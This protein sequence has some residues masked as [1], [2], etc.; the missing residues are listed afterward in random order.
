M[1]PPH[2]F[3]IVGGGAMGLAAAWQLTRSGHR[4][5]VLD[6][7]GPGNLAGASHGATRNYN[8]A[9]AEPHYLALL[10]EAL[11]RWRDLEAQSGAEL[12]SFWG[13]VT[14]GDPAEVHAAYDALNARM[15][16]VTML[17]ASQAR[18]R[19][20][21]MR[22]DGEV[23]HS[24]EAGVVRAPRALS[25]LEGCAESGGAEIRPGVRATGIELRPAGVRISVSEEGGRPLAPIDAEH[26]IVTAGAWTSGLLAG[27]PGFDDLP[28]ITVTEEQPEH[29]PVWDAATVWPSFNH[30]RAAGEADPLVGNVYGM[31]TPGE[32][33]KVGL[34][35]VGPTVD[36][37]DRSFEAVPELRRAL[38]EYVAEWFPGVDAT[39][40]LP[41]SCTY[42]NTD[43]G[44][45]VLDR[46]G[47]VT[48]GAGFS[49][50]GFKFVP[51]IGRV[52][53]DLATGTAIAP[54]A[55]Q[56]AR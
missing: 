30:F 54:P 25:A 40:G 14:H 53:A 12:L 6:R 17:S 32:G 35:R 36:P 46:R 9:Y 15:R 26:V 41:V 47:P 8:D 44:R 5:L 27:V 3:V 34:H 42:A 52:L 20:S 18:A 56:I 21:G 48:V 38:R 19:Y 45:F 50:H 24:A 51:A 22:F 49:G 55:F 37:D 43:D 2:D 28:G 29:F 11:P 7:F 31:P 23:L 39:R 1:T 10:D 16:P 33:I 13:L 4:P